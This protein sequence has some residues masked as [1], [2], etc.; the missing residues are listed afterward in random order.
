MNVVAF[1]SVDLRRRP[2]S[3]QK[4][5][6]GSAAGSHDPK[7]GGMQRRSGVNQKTVLFCL[8][9]RKEEEE[10]TFFACVF[11]RITDC[12]SLVLAMACMLSWTNPTLSY[13]L[14]DYN[15]QYSLTNI[16]L[17]QYILEIITIG[18]S[19]TFFIILFNKYIYYNFINIKILLNKR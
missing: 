4:V 11:L 15:H 8:F 14:S 17:S 10:Q 9:Q 18:S 16:F 1:G 7:F 2:R 19:N 12:A 6:C 3:S 5:G 13:F